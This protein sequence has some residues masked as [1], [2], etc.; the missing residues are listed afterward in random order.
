M[1]ARFYGVPDMARLVNRLLP[2]ASKNEKNKAMGAYIRHTNFGHMSALVEVPMHKILSTQE[3][4]DPERLKY[5]TEGGK[6]YRLP[7]GVFHNGMYYVRDGHH[8]IS[9]AK[10]AGKQSVRMWV[11]GPT[12]EEAWMLGSKITRKP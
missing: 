2:L 10:A 4:L 6:A 1:L 5:F 7:E 9:A 8:T 11:Y 12:R 3:H